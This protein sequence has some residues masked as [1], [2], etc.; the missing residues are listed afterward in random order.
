MLSS[1]D[2]VSGKKIVQQRKVQK[3]NQEDDH[4]KTWSPRLVAEEKHPC[5]G[6]PDTPYQREEEDRELADP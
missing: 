3:H 5:D 4:L 2:L 6:P 1:E